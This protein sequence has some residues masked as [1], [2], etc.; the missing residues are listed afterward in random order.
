MFGTCDHHLAHRRRLDPLQRIVEVAGLDR[1]RVEHL[2]RDGLLGEVELGHD[3]PHRL[4]RR[5]AG[6]RGEVGADEAVGAPRQL[7]EV[8]AVGQ[9]HAAGVDAEDLAPAALVGH[10][11]DDLAVEAAGPAQRLVERLGPVG[12]GDDHQILPRLEPVHQ[13]QQLGDQPLLGLAGDLAALGR[14]RS[15]SRR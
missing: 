13:R 5:L 12:G 3:P 2:G 6:Q 14:D 15:R 4:E 10:A 8:D 9:R 7:V 1:Q 11:D